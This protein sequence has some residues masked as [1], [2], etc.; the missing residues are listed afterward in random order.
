MKAPTSEHR[1]RV[2][3][4]GPGVPRER[5]RQQVEL[6][7]MAHGLVPVNGSNGHDGRDG[8]ERTN[9]DGDGAAIQEI[10]G[11]LLRSF[12]EQQR[13]L[14]AHRC[15]A[16]ARVEAFLAEHFADVGATLRLPDQTLVLAEHGVARE[17]SLPRAS[18][19]FTGPLLTSYRVRNGVLHNPRSDRRTTH[20]TFHVAEGG[21]PVPGDKKAV[22]KRVFGELFKR[23]VNPP[24]DLMML[25][26][27]A[28][29]ERPART[30]VSLLLRPLVCPEVPGVCASKTME[31]R[32]F[33]P[34]SLVSNLDFVESI[35]GN[36]G[37]PA[38]PENDAGLDVEHWTGHTGCV[39]LAPHLVNLTKKE[40]GLPHADQATERQKRD[41]MCWKD[42]AEK[43]NE[44]SA[45]KLTC[46]TSA[47]VVV[48]LIADN[49]YGYCKKEVKTQVSYAANLYGNVEEEHAG[50]ALAFPSW[51]LGTEYH[52]SSSSL[53]TGRTFK[54]VAR[55]YASFIDVR[56]EGY[57]VDRRFPQLIYIPEHSRASVDRQQVWWTGDDGKEHALPLRPGHIYMSPWGG[58]MRFEKH[59]GAP[60][61]R[62][63][64]TGGDG[65]FCHKP[66]TVSG[67]GKSEISKSLRDYMLYG[68][69]FVADAEKDLAKVREILAYDFS[70]R[71]RADSPE[72]P[73]YPTGRSRPLLSP[74]RSLGSVIKLLTPS[75]E[76]TEEYNAWVTSIPNYV[77]AMLF[78][79]KRFHKQ[80]WGDAWEQ[81]FS[82]DVVNGFP[83]HELKLEGRKLVG[84]YLRVGLLPGNA[85]RT[86]KL[87]QDFAAA[88]KVQ[89]EDDISASVVVPA[90]QLENLPPG[91]NAPS[92]KFVHN[93][94]Y[95]LFQRPDEAIHRGFDEQ[96]ERDLSEPSNFISNFQPLTL[97]EV[98][99]IVAHV[100]DFEQFTPPMKAMLAAAAQQPEGAS[101]VV[102]SDR[103]RLVDGKP[104]KNPRYLQ[105]RPD[106]VNPLDKYVAEVGLRLSRAVPAD[107]PV[108]IPVDAVLVGRRNNPPDAKAGIR[109]L[110]VY[111]PIHYQELPELFMDFVCSLTGKS[112]STTGA[113]S[114][115]ALT[116]S[117]FN[118]LRPIIDLNNALVSYILTGLG[119]FSTSAGHVGPNVRVDH[120][121]SLLVPEIWCR[122]SPQERDPAFMIANGYLEPL[123]DFTHH[124]ERIPASRLGYRIT[125][126]F[127]R[128]FFGRIFDHPTKVF[129]ELILKPE[130]QDIDSFVDG[131]KNIA[132]A[133]QR[134]A[135]TYLDDGSIRDASPPL[136][137][138]LLIMATGSWEGKDAHD[139]SFRR[140]FTREY[141]LASD[142]YRRRLDAK[143][144]ADAAL[145]RRHVRNLDA[146]LADP[147]CRG[148]AD[149]LQLHR[150]RELALAE[151]ERA[152]SQQYRA[153]LEG[154]LGLD[155]SAAATT[156]EVEPAATAVA[157]G[158]L[159]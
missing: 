109:A 133:Q 131:I 158:V 8:H 98:R 34:G 54:D 148:E 21:L 108:H 132:E 90:G 152:G 97:D 126:R 68:P 100:A 74:Q 28:Q 11:G 14:R 6:L 127:V 58:K 76:F 20:G 79:I 22:P 72:R 114:E 149:R 104:T 2:L 157:A 16:D 61:W 139:P 96:T 136:R 25:P 31:V 123:G 78:I 65:T 80:E 153:Q 35:F 135:Q 95:R 27:T 128:G 55:D 73:E 57:G 144:A 9:G 71:W 87:R 106:M 56:P 47:G 92:Y 91:R 103:P 70:K 110:A 119:G 159:G 143:Q 67:G 30:F 99:D 45:F 154:T 102:S 66:S 156:S 125:E 140:M 86:F 26:Y 18:D 105:T 46:R 60:S 43:Y 52:P 155:P 137:A 84:T 69:I 24:D 64:G 142:W 151:L 117:P 19:E 94:E 39:I 81:H 112:P 44:G 75:T 122:L 48:T 33:S 101:Y 147:S 23:A 32:F 88:A 107:K 62:L 10:A 12:R 38:L 145:W 13:R 42:A 36:A 41:G 141:L 146:F 4:I 77:L 93:C 111:N 1:Q 37:D 5:R 53:R 82:V 115:G 118:M 138:L 83:G 113:G 51:S 134:V 129:D 63:I 17:L 120:D 121:I 29:D 7:L 124:G 59:P 40:L 89:T 116:K 150:R 50:G 15:A 3:G 85:W 130:L 49:Y